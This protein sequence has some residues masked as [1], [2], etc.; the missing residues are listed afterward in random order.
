M[1]GPLRGGNRDLGAP[2]I[3]VKMSMVGPLGGPGARNLE[4]PT[5]NVKKH[6]RCA[7]W[8][9]LELEIQE[10]PPS[11]IQEVCCKSA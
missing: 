3:N 10:R 2:I 5:I 7:P 1:A 4:M 9:V 8:E 6:R 11:G